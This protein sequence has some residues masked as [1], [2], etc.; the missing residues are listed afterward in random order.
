MHYFTSSEWIHKL[1]GNGGTNMSLMIEDDNV[2]VKYNDVWNKI[3][4]IKG[5]KFHS[6]LVYDEKYIKAKVKEFDGVVNRNVWGNEVPKEGVHYTCI[7]CINIDP[8][9]KM[10][11]KKLSTNLFRR[12]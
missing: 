9:M 1:F 3:K 8:V 10:D 7:A 5:I 12:M 6:N 11:K 2:L 4:E